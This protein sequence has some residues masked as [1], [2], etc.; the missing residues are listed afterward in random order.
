MSETTKQD[1][2]DILKI[3]EKKIKVIYEAADPDY[4][5]RTRKEIET[6]KEKFN[7][8]GEYGMEWNRIES[9]RLY[10]I[11]FHVLK[12]AGWHSVLGRKFGTWSLAAILVMF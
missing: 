6:V 1:A 12:N 11:M 7:V 8:K 4:F 5:P 9:N 2:V 3:P 10:K